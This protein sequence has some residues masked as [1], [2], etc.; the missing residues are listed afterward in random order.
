MTYI[1]RTNPQRSSVVRRSVV[2]QSRYN[3]G[4]RFAVGLDLGQA[5]DYTAVVIVERVAQNTSSGSHDQCRYLHPIEY[6]VRHIERFELGTR[7]PD[8]VDSISALLVDSLLAG[9]SRLVVDGT[10]VGAPV[11][12]MFLHRG[13]KP[14]PVYITGADRIS[15]TGRITRVPKRD[16]VSVLQVLFQTARL[17]I[18]TDLELASTLTTE[19]TNFTARITPSFHETFACWRES[20][21]DDLVLAL[22]IA[23]W[24]FERMGRTQTFRLIT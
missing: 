15:H 2:R 23:C 17:R 8:I 6:H 9:H 3:V 1:E 4:P 13:L 21:H 12:D 7:Y 22:S 16:L 24:Y 10:G 18:A 19:L 11:V 20:Q 5:R 14:V